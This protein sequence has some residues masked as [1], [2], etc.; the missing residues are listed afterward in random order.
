MSNAVCWRCIED[1]YLKKIVQEKGEPEE[2]SLCHGDRENA[3][4]A[5][6]LAEI[7]DPVVRENFAQGPV[8]PSIGEG[9]DDRVYYEQK[10]D[11]LSFHLQDVIGQFLGFEE[12]VVRAL[13]RNEDVWP[14]DGEEAFFD[15]SQDYVP[16]PVRPQ[17]YHEEWNFVT[18]DL[19]HRRRFFSSAAASLFRGLLE[20]VE[21][22]PWWNSE[23]RAEERVVWELPAGSK[24][25]R[26]R[27]W[28]SALTVIEASKDPLKHIGPPSP[29]EARAGRM[30]VD[31][32]VAFYGAMDCKT[33]LAEVRPALG[34]DTAVITLSTTKSLR[35]LDFTRL[36]KS[37]RKLSYFQP[38][39]AKQCEKG[40]FLRQLQ[41][42]ISQPVVPG[43]E[44]EYL[45]TQTM[46]EYLAH[47]HATPFEGVLYK[48]VQRSGGINIVL[49]SD[50]NGEF[51]LEYL[52]KTFKIFSTESIQYTHEER[53]FGLRDEDIIWFDRGLDED[54]L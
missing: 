26:A 5:E 35:L 25:F 31:G 18:E 2:C 20:G 36:E 46:A 52:D 8:E 14:Q 6:G 42:L 10:G 15:G 21:E 19:K 9:D 37:H 32:V 53:R 39:F 28:P 12:E 41:N 38:D 43:R 34:N 30:N 11:P 50:P 7:L 47:V 44:Q 29:S 45:I 40:A 22:M 3:V 27:I 13:V 24:L 49:F 48:S 51:P 33:C 54:E 16:I 17:S 1:E 4:T 23:T